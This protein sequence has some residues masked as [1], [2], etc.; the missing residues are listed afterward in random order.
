MTISTDHHWTFSNSN[1]DSG[2]GIFGNS[3]GSSIGTGV[4]GMEPTGMQGIL[5]GD[6]IPEMPFMPYGMLDAGEAHPRQT[7]FVDQEVE[8]NIG[9]NDLA[10]LQR[11]LNDQSGRMHDLF[12]ART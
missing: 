3:F 9:D 4:S 10:V 2:T 7:G 12:L 5:G 1:S 11:F 8:P 6:M